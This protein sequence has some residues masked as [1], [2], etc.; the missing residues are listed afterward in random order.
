MRNAARS[1]TTEPSARRTPT[2]REP[3]PRRSR[4][5]LGL[6]T[7]VAASILLSTSFSARAQASVCKLVPDDRNAPEEI[8]RCGDTLEVR[9]GHDTNY[10]LVDQKGMPQPRE[11]RLD[12]GALK[13][14]FHPSNEHPTFQIRTPYAI[15]AVR[16]TKWVVEVGSGKMSTFVIE[17]NVAVSRPNGEQTVLLGPSQGA[18]VSPRSR[19]IVVARWPAAR[20]RALLAR[21]GQQ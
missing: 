3:S 10:N 20:V 7:V 21:F 1:K 15:A 9:S 6:T 8:L 14:E 16:G 4:N 19:P 13:I 18:D 2:A 11:L 5:R 17:G 12:G